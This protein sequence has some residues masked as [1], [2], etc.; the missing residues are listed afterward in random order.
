MQQ[1]I[2][3]SDLAPPPRFVE[4]RSLPF[5]EGNFPPSQ[6]EEDHDDNREEEEEPQGDF[7]ENLAERMEESDLM[8]LAADLLESIAEDEASRKE[9]DEANDKGFKYLGFLLEEEKDVPFMK[10]CR[11]FDPTLATALLRFYATARAELFPA[12]GPV[13]VQTIGEVNSAL[14]DQGERIKTWM[15]YYLTE[16]DTEYYPDSERLL[17]YLGLVGCAFR[18]VYQDPV[19]NRSVARFINPQDFIVNNDCVSLLSSDR[20]THV[21]HLSK[22]EIMLRQMSGFYRDTP[23]PLDNEGNEEESQTTK[24]VQKMDGIKPPQ[25]EKKKS[26]FTIYETH[27]DLALDTVET[28]ERDGEEIHVPL[29]YIVSI[30]KTTRKILSI[31]RNWEE[32]DP[33]HKRIAYFVQYNYLPG[34]GIYG[35]GLTRLLGSNAIVLTSLLRQLVD[36]GTLNNFPGGLRVKGLK[37]DKNDKAIGPSEFLEVETGGLPIRDAIMPMPYA[38][39]SVVLKELRNEL[40]QQTQNLASMAETQVSENKA[41]APVG[42]VLALLEVSNRVQ[43]SVLRSLHM[44]LSY[45]FSLLYKLFG[46]Y[47][48]DVPYPFL[49]PGKELSIMRK[50]FNDRL[51][52]VPVSDP[53]L[54]TST[55]RLMRA[56]AELQLAQS[57]PQLYNMKNVHKR[58][59]EAMHVENIDE[60]LTPDMEALPLDPVTENM[61][62]LEG[63]PVKAAVWQDHPAHILVH[64]QFLQQNPD[65]QAE[66]MEHVNVHRAY[67]Y[68]VKMQLALGQPLPPL[69]EIVQPEIQNMIALQV[70]QVVQQQQQA[71]AEAVRQQTVD[72]N[73]VMMMDIEQRREAASL[74]HEEAKLKSDT[75]IFK[76]QLNFE[77]EKNKQKTQKELAEE[78]NETEMEI[79]QM[80]LQEKG[81]D[82]D[83]ENA[84][85]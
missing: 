70:A 23:L 64:T 68:A 80:K 50:D 41:D 65:K 5:E 8:R 77:A 45:E 21:L 67:D 74:K 10:A 15:N 33:D 82:Y 58:V 72:P 19:L 25:D 37:L 49:V 12:Q 14:E 85:V 29:P 66:I 52:V 22:K 63:R 42:T 39:P 20:L 51:K 47:L 27:C 60:I 32:D 73:Q 54:T 40:V 57:A 35:L 26:L 81:T 71:Q 17:M 13:N 4:G 75:E 3:P 61:N 6:E 76:A 31:R 44:S 79:Q 78:K 2:F 59:C 30:C 84:E 7:H 38:E 56:Q 53:T 11:V 62:I 24:T 36:K 16:M 9:W 83:T 48:P 28:L 55:Q 69:E 34:F 18:K 46:K 43:S 1:G